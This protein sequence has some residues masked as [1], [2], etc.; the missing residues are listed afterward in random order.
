MK[1]LVS[2]RLFCFYVFIKTKFA[3]NSDVQ[4]RMFFIFL[5]NVLKQTG[6]SFN[7]KF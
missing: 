3:K 4:V 1:L 6:N 7:T 5:K 2:K